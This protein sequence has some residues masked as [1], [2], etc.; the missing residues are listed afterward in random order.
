MPGFLV[1]YNRRNGDWRVTE[2]PGEDGHQDALKR[3]LEL[4]AERV[5]PDWEIASLNSDSLDTV[6]KTHARYFEGRELIGA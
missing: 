6:Q 2:F 5:D 3:R 4:E 1:E